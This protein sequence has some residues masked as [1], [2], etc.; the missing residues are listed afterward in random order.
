M[1]NNSEI[2][3]T[4]CQNCLSFTFFYPP[5]HQN[6][7]N[8]DVQFHLVKLISYFY[9]LKAQRLYNT[10]QT[11]QTL[12]ITEGSLVRVIRSPNFGK[13]GTVTDLPPE[14]RKM[15]SETMVRIA[16]IDIDGA[17]FEIPRSNLEVVETD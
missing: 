8:R 12:G 11:E 2:K 9:C 15:E 6:L 14:L 17:Q 16:I 10:H 3:A 13:I 4:T 1:K 5:H 7:T